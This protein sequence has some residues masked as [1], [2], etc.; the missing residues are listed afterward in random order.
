[1]DSL[2]SSDQSS[3]NIHAA[4]VHPLDCE[5]THKMLT[6]IR[7]PVRYRTPLASGALDG[8]LRHFRPSAVAAR[9]LLPTS[10]YQFD[11]A[12]VSAANCS[13][14]SLSAIAQIRR[15]HQLDPFSSD[16]NLFLCIDLFF[17]LLL[18]DKY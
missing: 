3:R 9:K 13:Y 10:K 4:V 12:K 17:G 14:I 1:M 5:Q 8:W 11:L 15:F 18:V 7:R 2:R 6:L 16:S